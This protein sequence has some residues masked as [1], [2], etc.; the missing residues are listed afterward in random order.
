MKL[1]GFL[2]QKQEFILGRLGLDLITILAI[3]KQW[4]ISVFISIKMS[5]KKDTNEELIKIQDKIPTWRL[6]PHGSTFE[7]QLL[8]ALEY[9]IEEIKTIKEKIN[10]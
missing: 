1:A 10:I 7:C 4:D 6:G 9:L 2:E 5:D 3:K 8:N